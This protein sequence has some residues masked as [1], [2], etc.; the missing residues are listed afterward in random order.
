MTAPKIKHNAVQAPAITA[1]PIFFFLIKIGILTAARAHR[2]K[3]HIGRK[4]FISSVPVSRQ[5][6]ANTHISPQRAIKPFRTVTKG[7]IAF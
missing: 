5:N 7:A 4:I 2:A 6:A 3:R 1:S